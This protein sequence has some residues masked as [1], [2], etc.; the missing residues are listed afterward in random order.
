MQKSSTGIYLL[1]PFT[2]ADGKKISGAT[3]VEDYNVAIGYVQVAMLDYYK[4]KIYKDYAVSM[5][6]ENDDFT[7]N[8]ITF[9]GEMRLHQYF[10]ENYTGAFIYDSFADIIAAIDANPAP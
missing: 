2:T 6:W 7:K 3:I 1:P 4:I 5:G 8:L 10:S 9:I